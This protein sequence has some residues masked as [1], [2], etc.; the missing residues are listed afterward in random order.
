MRA[1]SVYESPS[2]ERGKDPKRAMR[3]GLP[4]FEMISYWANK[5]G[6]KG[7]GKTEDSDIFTWRKPGVGSIH[8]SKWPKEMLIEVGDYMI[9]SELDADDPDYAHWETRDWTDPNTW[10]KTFGDI[11]INESVS[12][13]RGKDPIKIMDLGVSK[14]L[15]PFSLSERMGFSFNESSFITSTLGIDASDIYQLGFAGEIDHNAWNFNDYTQKLENLVLQGNIISRKQINRIVTAVVSDTEIGRIA[16]I[17]FDEEG[18]Y[19]FSDIKPAFALELWKKN[20]N[21]LESL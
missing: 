8:Y 18:A 19:Y 12:F 21:E 6:F 7:E 5:F 1:K 11:L 14:L 4:D 17:I 13:Q 2:F 10:L 3:I 16:K 9:V 20:R 15:K